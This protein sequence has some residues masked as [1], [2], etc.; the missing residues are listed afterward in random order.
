MLQQRL[1]KEYDGKI[2]N[3]KMK[4]SQIGVIADILWQVIP[5]HAKIVKLGHLR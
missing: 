2:Q 5:Q 4:I 1:L 3:G